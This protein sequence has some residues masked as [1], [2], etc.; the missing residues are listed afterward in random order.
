MTTTPHNFAVQAC[1]YITLGC[2][3]VMSAFTTPYIASQ[4]SV[5]SHSISLAAK[6]RD[7]VLKSDK[8]IKS[9]CS[10][11]EVLTSVVM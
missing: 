3:Q 9:A 8:L 1:P 6:F 5:L 4:P 11:L 7:A 2:R 10:D